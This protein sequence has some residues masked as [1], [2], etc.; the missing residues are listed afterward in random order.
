MELLHHVSIFYNQIYSEINAIQEN[1]QNLIDSTISLLIIKIVNFI[2]SILFSFI[3]PQ[4]Q[5]PND[6]LQN[7]KFF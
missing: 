6:Q 5:Q 4:I 2:Y 1:K 7:L 3:K